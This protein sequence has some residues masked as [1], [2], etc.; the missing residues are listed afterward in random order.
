MIKKLSTTMRRTMVCDSGML[1]MYTSQGWIPIAMYQEAHVDRSSVQVHCGGTGPNGQ[2]AHGYTYSHTDYQEVATP[3]TSTHFLLGKPE[4]DT[5]VEIAE[6]LEE[7]RTRAD[8]EETA[9]K[10]AEQEVRDRGTAI[11]GWERS[12]KALEA[13]AEELREDRRVLKDQLDKGEQ[14]LHDEREKVKKLKDELAR[15]VTG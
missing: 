12:T 7:A 15:R 10:A 6:K 3:V 4:E 11:K 5:V 13:V 14:A 1:D 2:C 8:R 9:R